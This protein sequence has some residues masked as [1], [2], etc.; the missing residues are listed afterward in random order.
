MWLF[1]SNEMCAA[2]QNYT[3]ISIII[4]RSLSWLVY[5]KKK[6]AYRKNCLW[7]FKAPHMVP[8]W[9]RCMQ[10]VSTDLWLSPV[11]R[12]VKRKLLFSHGSSSRDR[13]MAPPYGLHLQQ[14]Y[15]FSGNSVWFTQQ[16]FTKHLSWIMSYARTGLQW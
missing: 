5:K 9:R 7:D 6:A 10:M 1:F 13:E 4:L 12:K 3:G 11:V 14:F 16:I 2:F 8:F 15:F